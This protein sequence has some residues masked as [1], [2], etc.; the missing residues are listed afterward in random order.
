MHLKD[1]LSR[2]AREYHAGRSLALILDFDGTLAPLVTHP[3]LATCA[4]ATQEIL[5]SLGRLPRLV[6]GIVSGRAL[7]DLKARISLPSFIYAGTFGFELELP[8]G[9]V[10]H[11]DARRYAPVV[12]AAAEVLAAVVAQFPGAW[13]E[14]KPLALTVHYRQVQREE[15]PFLMQGVERKLAPFDGVLV[16]IDGSMAIEVLPDVGWDKGEVVHAI[17]ERDGRQALPLYAG[18]DDNDAGAMQAALDLGGVA[19]GVGPLIPPLATHRL[20]DVESFVACLG[21]LHRLLTL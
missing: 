11:P 12:L 18:N 6:A 8:G 3:D 20:P 16:A 14:H 10:E 17:V 2:L 19:I 21:E 4:D 9:L 5:N 1:D 7:A 15:I 13:I